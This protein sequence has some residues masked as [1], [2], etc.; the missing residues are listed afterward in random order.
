MLETNRNSIS[1]GIMGVI[2]V[3]V[4]MAVQI[5][6]PILAPVASFVVG[7]GYVFIGIAVIL[8]LIEVLRGVR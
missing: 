4:A 1:I 2:L 5:L 8:F 3:I 6:F 7:V